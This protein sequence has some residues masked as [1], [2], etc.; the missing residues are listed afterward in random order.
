MAT[1]RLEVR[2]NFFSNRVIDCWTQI[3]SM[4]TKPT[5]PDWSMEYESEDETEKWR[6][7]LNKNF[8]RER[9]QR[10]HWNR[11][12]GSGSALKVLK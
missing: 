3:P 5:K 11:I 6:G 12:R 4:A 1:T 9:P 8:L 10:G 2:R 7:K